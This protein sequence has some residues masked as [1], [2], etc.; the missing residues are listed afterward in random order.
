MDVEVVEEYDKPQIDLWTPASHQQ[1]WETPDLI[2]AVRLDGLAVL[3]PVD[4]QATDA[5]DLRAVDH[6]ALVLHC[7]CALFALPCG[8]QGSCHTAPNG[9]YFRARPLRFRQRVRIAPTDSDAA[10]DL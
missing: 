7:L 3:R 10:Q 4:L 9:F 1:R 5:P 6:E 8:K 2:L